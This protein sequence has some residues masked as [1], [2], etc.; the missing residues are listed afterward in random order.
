MATR[1]QHVDGWTLVLRRQPT[2][3]VHGQPEDG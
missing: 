1:D 3:T 2:W